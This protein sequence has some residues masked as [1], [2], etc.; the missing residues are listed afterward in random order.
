MHR[1]QLSALIVSGAVLSYL[2]Q[3]VFAPQSYQ[4]KHLVIPQQD[5]RVGE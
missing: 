3:T 5:L 1:L 4:S 2:F